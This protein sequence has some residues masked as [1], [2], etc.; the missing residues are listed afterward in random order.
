MDF[1][2]CTKDKEI[3]FWYA[4]GNSLMSGGEFHNFHEIHY[5]FRAEG[6]FLS[7]EEKALC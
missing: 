1:N 3:S 5:I 6:S 4:K 7:G 2:Y